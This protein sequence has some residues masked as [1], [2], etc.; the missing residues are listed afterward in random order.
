[1]TEYRPV[2]VGDVVQWHPDAGLN[3][4]WVVVAVQRGGR[5]TIETE[6]VESKGMRTERRSVMQRDCRVVGQQM[7][8]E[9]D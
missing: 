9:M 4:D 8:M 3:V 6:I 5:L 2:R 1:M 7:A